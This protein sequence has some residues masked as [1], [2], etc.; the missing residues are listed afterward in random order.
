MNATLTETLPIAASPVSRKPPAAP[1][2]PAPAFQDWTRLVFTRLS[3]RF[4]HG[5]GA[6]LLDWAVETF[7]TGLTIGTGFGASGI[8]LM[9][10]ALRLNPDVD[11]FY[12]DTGYFFAETEF[13]IQRLEQHY[14]RALRRV[15]TE[16]SI[17]QQAKRYGPELYT[18]DPNLCCHI[19]KVTPLKK[20]LL[21]STAWATALRHDQSSSRKDVRMVQWNDRYNVVKIAPLVHWTEADIWAYIHEHKLP[22][23]TLHDQNYPSIGCWPCTQ[24]VAPGDDLRAGRWQGSTK[25]ECG[26]HWELAERSLNSAQL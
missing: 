14:Q 9:D 1:V 26:L 24:P 17:E 22:Y 8:V 13:L 5:N 16:I 11:I 21:D 25:K 3:Q 4:E 18:N 2:T 10:M 6:D 7:G 15:S 23:N 12:I 19:R 20:A